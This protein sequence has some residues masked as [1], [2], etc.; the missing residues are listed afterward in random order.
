MYTVFNARCSIFRTTKK[1]PFSF[2]TDISGINSFNIFRANNPNKKTI[3]RTYTYNL[4]FAFMEENLEHMAILLT[5]L[6]ELHSF[7][8]KSLKNNQ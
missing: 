4:A 7:L 5:L 2:F 8:K 6:Q 3:R 1:W